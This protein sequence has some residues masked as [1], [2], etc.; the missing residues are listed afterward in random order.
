M[1]DYTISEF[2]ELPSKGKIYTKNVNPNIKLRSMT[3]EE[4]MRRLSPTDHPYKALCDIIDT[5][6]IEPCG[7]SSYD[8]CLGDYQYLL[9]QLRIITYGSDYPSSSIC[10]I[11]GKVNRVVLDLDKIQVL[12][13]DE[14]EIKN[15]MSFEL[16]VSKKKIKLKY[17]TP[18]DIDEIE[19]EEKEFKL[20]NPE[21]T[22]NISYLISL[23]HTIDTVDDK[24]VDDFKLDHFLRHLPMKD[25][26]ILL[27]K[28]AKINEKVGIDT[29]ITNKC[30]NPNCGATYQTSFRI[31]NEFFGP[32]ID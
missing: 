3:T 15:I 16:P 20:K 14:E 8:M 25:T 11:C 12:K 30:A 17:Q 9:H 29:R 13:F 10:P 4:E 21:S 5:C 1:E 32:T 28:A 6:M 24:K 31:T 2:C 7:I 22:I 23:R 26:N 27:Q 18:R 19:Q